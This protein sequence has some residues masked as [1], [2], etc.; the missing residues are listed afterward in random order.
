MNQY[1]EWWR[2]PINWIS[3]LACNSFDKSGVLRILNF[4]QLGMITVPIVAQNRT[5][6][7]YN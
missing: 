3:L 7:L 4:L 2:V 6:L 5:K 1:E